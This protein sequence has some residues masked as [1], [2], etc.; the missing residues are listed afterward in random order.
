MSVGVTMVVSA[1]F[2]V[3]HRRIPITLSLVKGPPV[4]G[5][6]SLD[7]AIFATLGVNSS[8]CQA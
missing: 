6:A 5:E 8:P 2:P 1:I 4:C 7:R 3:W